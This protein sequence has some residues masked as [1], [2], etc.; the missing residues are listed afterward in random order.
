VIHFH[1]LPFKVSLN[2][3][4]TQ[5]VF[6]NIL[7]NLYNSTQQSSKRFYSKNN[8]LVRRSIPEDAPGV[9]DLYNKVTCKYPNKL[10]QEIDELTLSYIQDTLQLASKR[11]LVLLMFEQEELIGYIKAYTS[12][13][14]RHAHILT[15]A[16]AMMNPIR[17]NQG[18]DNKLL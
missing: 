15:N 18:N 1:P 4:M 8:L 2:E 6:R 11:G 14:R 7:L 10:A 16:T 13:Y 5:R 12:E 17:M 3:R 9:L